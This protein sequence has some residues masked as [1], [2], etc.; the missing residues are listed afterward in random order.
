MKKSLLACVLAGLLSGG[1][2]AAG[3]RQVLALEQ[4]ST[5]LGCPSDR[6]TA[7]QVGERSFE[8]AGCGRRATYKVICK[9]TVSSCYLSGGPE[10]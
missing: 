7:R 2:V 5:E 6:L 1:C 3:D 8:T 10:S 9:L 4:A